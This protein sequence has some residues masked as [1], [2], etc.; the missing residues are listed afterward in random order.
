MAALPA[1]CLTAGPASRLWSTSMSYLTPRPGTDARQG[2]RSGRAGDTTVRRREAMR[3][4]VGP[5]TWRLVIHV[6]SLLDGSFQK[7]DRADHHQRDCG[8]GQGPPTEPVDPQASVGNPA[9]ASHES[10]KQ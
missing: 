2:V 9:Q 6:P 8:A 4:V 5:A 3:V 7:V 1:S 10:P